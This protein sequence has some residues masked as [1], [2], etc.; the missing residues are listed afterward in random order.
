MRWRRRGARPKRWLTPSCAPTIELA[1][2]KSLIIGLGNPLMG[3]DGVGV[4]VCRS[5]QSDPRLPEDAKVIEEGGT[6]LLRH[7]DRMIECD[8]VVLIDAMLAPAHPGQVIIVENDFSILK[9]PESGAHHLSAIQAVELL[10]IASPE[11]KKV[12]ITFALVC[13][14][15]VAQTS[16]LS[17]RIQ[18]SLPEI[19]DLIIHKLRT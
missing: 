15:S 9:N 14:E 7:A 1:M 3:D 10:R 6:D 11:A 13:I 8:H 12:K 5:L 18:A 16:T 2:S 4:H 19:S 17:A